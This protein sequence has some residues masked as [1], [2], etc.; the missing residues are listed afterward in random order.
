MGCAGWG[1]LQVSSEQMIAAI[2]YA[3]K[4]G[5]DEFDCAPHYGNG[6]R[7]S[8]LGI[9][10]LDLPFEVRQKIKISTKV[11]RVIN[12]NIESKDDTGFKNANTFTQ[13]FNYSYWG[14]KRS[15]EQ[16]QLRLNRRD[17]DALYLHDIDKGTHGNKFEEMMDSFLEDGYLAFEKLKKDH[18]ITIAG[19]GSNDHQICI[20][21]IK[22]GRFNIDRIMLAGCYNLLNFQALDELFPLCEKNNIE[23]YIAAPYCGGILGDQPGNRS[24]K[25][26]NAQSG[27]LQR[28]DELRAVCDRF[29][30][31]LAHAAMQFVHMHPQ[32]YRV[33]AGAR[34]VD[35]IRT[36]L[37]YA[38][39]PIDDK[40]WYALNE[41]GLIPTKS[42]SSLSSRRLLSSLSLFTE[43]QLI[44]N[45]GNG[46]MLRAH[47]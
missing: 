21:L 4:Q 28:V 47:L 25:Y 46:E 2:H 11:G 5:V 24:Y 40:F 33:V 36:S 31:G 15:Y 41:Q 35:E 18:K 32:V 39:T 22:D 45:D 44:T 9:A 16:S 20:D 37:E 8:V 34:S 42:I 7:E 19:I 6:A 1:S 30:V 14:I 12:P 27:V 26:E 13:H 23:L 29:G 10:L 43:Q 3:I 17:I 38:R